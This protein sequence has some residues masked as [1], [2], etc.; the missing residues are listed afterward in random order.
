MEKKKFFVLG[1][2][3]CLVLFLVAVL[4]TPAW[5]AE[6]KPIKLKLS[7]AYPARHPLTVNAYGVWAKKVEQRTN[8]QV[9]ITIFPG[10]TLAK[11]KENYDATI[12]GVCDIGFFPQAYAAGRFPVSVGMNLP[13]LFPSAK[14]ASQVAWDIYNK[15]QEIQAE[16]S[17]VKLLLFY[18]T[19]PYEIHTV[20]KPIKTMGDLKGLQIRAAGP[21]AAGI[22]T[23]LGGTPV[24]ISMPEA[25]MGLQK[26]VLD[27]LVSPFG[28]MKGFKTADVTHYH[29]MNATLFSNLFCVV[30][31]LKKWN[32]LS[33]NIQRIIDEE[34]GAAGSKLFGTA[35]DS[36]TAPDIKYMKNQGDT[37]T[38]ISPEEKKRW[39]TAIK[40]LRDKWVN[41]MLGK[42]KPAKEILS[43]MIRL[44]DK[45][46][47]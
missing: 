26:G 38:T 42:G 32:I 14:V 33:P 17:D 46:S 3:V 7:I 4:L 18:C 23:A 10:G 15:F 25:Y 5:A 1:L 16:Y 35:F 6:K 34:S 11:T 40:P 21:A 36:I 37:F 44:S 27:G 45:Y 31:N 20:K 19:P 28:P 8:G 29:T 24:A 39:A 9:K 13:M 12:A 43:E 41:K 47:D 30:M 2:F 22:T